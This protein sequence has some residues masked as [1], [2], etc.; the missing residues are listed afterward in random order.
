MK[1]TALILAAL[2]TG[3]TAAN[4]VPAKRV[5]RTFTQPDGTQITAM[6]VGDEF[7][8]AFVTPD[9]VTLLADAEGTLRYAKAEADGTLTLSPMAAADAD[10]RSAAARQFLAGADEES[11]RDAL[12]ARALDIRRVRTPRI[13]A[14]TPAKAD[15]KAA[16][17]TNKYAGL[18]LFTSNYPRKGKVKSL[19]FLVEYKDVKFRT[20]NTNDF[21][22]RML[23]QEGFSDYSG[24]GSARDYFLAQSNGNFD[25]EFDVYGP[26]TMKNNMS[27][28]GGNDNYGNDLR[29]EE[30]VLEAAEALADQ[31]DFSE[32]DF[33]NDGC[34]DNIYVIYAGQG[35]ADG[36][37]A[38]TVWPHSFEISKGPVY[39]GKRIFSYACSNEITDGIPCGIGTFCHEYG[40]VIGL[41]DLYATSSNLYCTPM[42]WDI[43]DQGSYSN[44]GR[45][46][47]A[48]SAY[49]RNAMTWNDPVVLTGAETV[50]LRHIAES[51]VSYLIPTQSDTE[52]FL[53]ENRQQ[54]GWDTYLPGHGMLIWHI[55]FDQTVWDR[56]AVNNNRSQQNVD[57][58]EANNNP[59]GYDTAMAGYPFPGTAKVRSFTSSTTPALVDWGRRPIDMPITDITENTDGTIT[60]NVCGGNFDLSVPEAPVLT[61]AADGTMKVE[62]TAVDRANGYD[63]CV[64]ANGTPMAAYTDFAVGNVTSYTLEG[65]NGNT[66]YAVKLRAT[67]GRILS[68]Y[69]AETKA[70]TPEIDF[71][72]TAP[73]ATSGNSANG[74]ATLEWDALEGAVDYLVTVEGFCDGGTAI[75]LVDGGKSDSALALP[76]GWTFSGKST[77]LYKST[78]V[79]FY[80][81]ASPSLKFSSNGMELVSPIYTGNVTNID[82]W[83]RGAN[84]SASSSMD[85]QGR[86]SESATWS[87]L[88]K[89]APLNVYNNAGSTISVA[90]N[91]EIRQIRFVFNK[92]SGNCA[93]DDV[94]VSHGQMTFSTIVAD[95]SAEGK[96]SYTVTVP[97]GVTSLRYSVKGVDALGRQS[98][99]SN[100]VEVAVSAGVADIESSAS[101][102]HLNGLTLTYT[103]NAADTV[104]V[105]TLSGSL[106]AAATA[107]AAGEATV[108]LPAAGLYIVATP[109]GAR[110]LIAK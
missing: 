31:I 104:K 15:A 22:N 39:N 96:L 73:V 68:D 2:L 11:L 56:N 97:A 53:L 24:T 9:G 102:L 65:L 107:T 25:P 93:I 66:E 94:K 59:S 50:T 76:E 16:D 19:V 7:G 57:I 8:H 46:P 88:H 35:E 52:F 44:N 105:Y 67:N 79:G 41:P 82:F 84:A 10:K 18:G 69:S 5:Y 27:Y 78:S 83:L 62:W 75:D 95:A 12:S 20:P 89:V 30:M 28:Y 26:V 71:I 100:L 14:K 33:D 38:N 45:T 32:Y 101:A 23:N 37:S 58:V 86:S 51:N 61:P 87:A 13:A 70:T 92:N 108:E 54:T 81:E 63:I 99:A 90:V 6:L 40:H 109:A 98:K 43:M 36:G 64:S 80:G 110:K 60:F 17:A 103:G 47:P 55:N 21:F 72:Y 42:T 29:P 48:Y 34:V 91:G 3:A 4:A 106:V 74:N 49:E 77:D 85:I 1:K